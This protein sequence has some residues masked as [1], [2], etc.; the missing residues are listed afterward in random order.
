M[1]DFQSPI[2]DNGQQKLDRRTWIER[3]VRGV[4]LGGAAMVGALLLKNRMTGR[5]PDNARCQLRNSCSECNKRGDCS[6]VR[7]R[8]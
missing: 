6:Y 3:T 8:R 4:A 2:N 7:G 1:N 5:Q